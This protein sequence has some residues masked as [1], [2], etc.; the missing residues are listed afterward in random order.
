MKCS[1][2]LALG[3][4][5][6]DPLQ[7]P[8][9][10]PLLHCTDPA[11]DI[12]NLTSVDLYPN[13]PLPGQTLDITARGSISKDIEEGA[14]IKLNVKYGLITILNMKADLCEHVDE[15]E[16]KCPLKKDDLSVLSKQV[17]LP[18][19]IPPGRY[20]VMADAYT[21][22]DERVTCLMAKVEFHRGSIVQQKVLNGL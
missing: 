11:N 21:K 9:E 2:L 1:A 18:K 19:Q 10:N 6:D 3:A 14:Y 5:V 22:D 4:A 20:T 17:E 8:G 13:P 12:L 16:L 7:V 15:V